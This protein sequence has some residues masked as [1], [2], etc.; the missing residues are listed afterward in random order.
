MA[1]NEAGLRQAGLFV[2]SLRSYGGAFAN[3]PVRIFHHTDLSVDSADLPANVS[4]CPIPVIA[5]WCQPYF[6]ASKVYCAAMAEE[7]AED[8]GSILVW[9]DDDTLILNEPDSFYLEEG[10]IAAFSPVMH[11]R[12]GV[13]WNHPPGE[14]WNYLD[15]VFSVEESDLFPLTA[16]ADEVEIR[17][18]FNA[19][20]M[21]VEPARRLMRTW[22][23]HFIP[24]CRDP[25]VLDLVAERPDDRI[26]LHQ[27]V[28]TEVLLKDVGKDSMRILPPA[29]NYPLFFEELFPAIRPFNDLAEA[30]T[31]RYD[32]FF[33]NPR[34]G[35]QDRLKGSPEKI[36]WLIGRLEG[37]MG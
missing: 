1:E 37:L 21:V 16:P 4:T 34:H 2:E 25:R 33:Q 19:G 5:D 22:K 26:F 27:M 11:N 32:A 6:F 17:A 14:L 12:T 9:V 31:A 28:L 30:I 23:Q 7:D 35:W 10:K 29:Y 3:A 8:A 36:A 13:T 15:A 20:L 18:Y 24:L